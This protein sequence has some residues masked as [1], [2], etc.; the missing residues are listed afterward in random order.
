MRIGA[1]VSTA[2]S[3]DLA[4]D[5]GLEIGAEAV[6]IFVS[7]PQGWAFKPVDEKVAAD[8]KA[9]ALEHG[10]GPTVIHGIYLVS[11]CS[12]DPVL[13]SRGKSSL[14]KY[15]NA[16]QDLGA[17]GI[18]FHLGSHKGRG[19]DT[20]FDQLV[21]GIQEVLH[22]SPEDVMLILEN[23]AGMGS[24]IGSK[25]SELGKVIRAIDDPRV[26]VCLDTQHSFA[27]GYDLTTPEGVAGVMD[28]FERE[29]GTEH[30]VAVHCNDSKPEFG[31]A[32]DRH[33]NIGEGHM[34]LA[35]FEAICGHPAFRDVPFYLEVPGFEGK[36]P[37][38]K[39]V[40]IMKGIRDK[41]ALPA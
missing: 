6:Q 11:L 28:E 26:H 29:I 13:V 40:E 1:H 27:A 18:I 10:F 14:I 22:E 36:G 2:N 24:H 12:D 38:A 8:Y 23:S 41:L 33:E 4:I 31:G 19:F 30:L 21:S 15:M 34:G 16:G 35:A 39:N 37:D 3:A 32:V 5:R 17:M 25:F 9:K 7:P 20:V